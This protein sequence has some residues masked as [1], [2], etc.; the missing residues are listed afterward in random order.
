MELV[1]KAK[2]VF[3]ACA[4]INQGEDMIKR[5]HVLISEGKIELVNLMGEVK[6]ASSGEAKPPKKHKSSFRKELRSNEEISNLIIEMVKKKGPLTNTVIKG[7]FNIGDRRMA[8]VL[9]GLAAQGRLKDTAASAG[10]HSWDLPHAQ[11]QTLPRIG[12]TGRPFFDEKAYV[13][14]ALAFL[15]T[16][17]W[18]TKGKLLDH[19]HISSKP[20]N[21]LFDYLEKQKLV[22]QVPKRNNPEHSHNKSIFVQEY[23]YWEIVL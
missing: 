17:D 16:N 14:P 21:R 12:K 11:A 9:G 10:R 8:Q 7:H 2:L 4:K 15:R 3:E 22:K 13:E 23:M 18:V 1:G 19:L 20:G 5:G 6:I